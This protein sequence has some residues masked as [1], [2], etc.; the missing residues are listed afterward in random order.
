MVVKIGKYNYLSSQEAMKCKGLHT[1]WC[2]NS[3]E[4]AGEIWNRTLDVSSNNR[5][6]TSV[7]FTAL[8]E[9]R[10]ALANETVNER[11]SNATVLHCQ[12]LAGHPRPQVTW[13]RNGRKL[14]AY[15]LAAGEGCRWVALCTP[16]MLFHSPA[17]CSWTPGNSSSC[18]TRHPD[19]DTALFRLAQVQV[20]LY[21]GKGH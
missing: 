15:N 4:A 11:E 10:V 19:P 2:N 20:A 7:V 5:A 1:L 13:F 6:L 18:V 14:K 9:P 8:S 12:V 21:E 16:R 3:G 17:S